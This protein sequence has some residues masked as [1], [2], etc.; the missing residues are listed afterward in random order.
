MEMRISRIGKRIR[1]ILS[2]KEAGAALPAVLAFLVLGALIITPLLGF[3]ITG[4]KAGQ[5]QEK[6]TGEFYSAD[7]GVEYAIWQ[8]QF[9]SLLEE[10]YVWPSNPLQLTPTPLSINNDSVDVWI[11]D[12]GERDRFKITS[13]ATDNATGSA[14]TVVT[15]VVP[16]VD[17]LGNYFANG[18]TAVGDITLKGDVVGNVECA[19]T[20]TTSPGTVIE[21]DVRCMVLDNGGTI[22]GNVECG[23]L[24]NKGVINKPEEDGYVK[25]HTLVAL[26]TI[27]PALPPPELTADPPDL[28]FIEDIWPSKDKLDAFYLPQVTDNWED[29]STWYPF[30]EINT[31]GE[32]PLIDSYKGVYTGYGDKKP[33]DPRGLTLSRKDCAVKLTTTVFVTGDFEVTPG[34]LLDLN[35]Q[36]VYVHGDIK[37]SPGSLLTGSGV[38]IAIGQI[39]FQPGIVSGGD[40]SDEGVIMRY[41]GTTWSRQ[42]NIYVGDLNDVWGISPGEV[43]AVGNGGLVLKGNGTSWSD[44]TTP[45]SGLSSP[46]NLNGVWCNPVS[47]DVFAVGNAGTTLRYDAVACDWTYEVVGTGSP[48]ASLNGVWG[49]VSDNAVYAVGEGGSAWRWQDGGWTEMSNAS[50]FSLNGVWGSSSDNVFAVGDGGT[51]RK[52]TDG[53]TWQ[54][55]G[56]SGGTA[57]TL[58]AIWGVSASEFYVV[59]G[60]QMGE[61]DGIIQCWKEKDD[62]W[63]V[64]NM[65]VLEGIRPVLRDI[66]GTSASNIYAVGEQGSIVR[67]FGVGSMWNLVDPVPTTRNLNGVWG[68]ASDDIFVVGQAVQDFVFVQSVDSF[69]KHLPNGDFHG[70]IAGKG[71]CTLQPGSSLQAPSDLGRVNFPEY[72]YMRIEGYVIQQH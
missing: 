70:S 50:P 44:V 60:T 25:Y 23:T 68:T 46:P 45:L 65:S 52:C 51:I 1:R 54:A 35:G 64:T 12:L 8:L 7:A 31:C 59:G 3:M 10:D 19:G 28:D 57:K 36:T 48:P 24:N 14:T 49:S 58:N 32:L 63:T 39:D 20:L 18:I 15:R 9:G 16:D 13:T 42:T 62:V 53:Q 55:W 67:Y 34:T 27:I 21:G 43:Y 33:D 71:E 38:I 30:M 40:S 4:L 56:A 2:G 29:E 61:G 69:V 11:E 5:S 66:W 22:I 6:R 47:G 41:N 72:R 37:F 26:G 17:Y